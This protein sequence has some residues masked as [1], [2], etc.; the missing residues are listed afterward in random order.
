MHRKRY[1]Q[2]YNWRIIDY[3]L[4][5]IKKGE[6]HQPFIFNMTPAREKLQHPLCENKAIRWTSPPQD[7]KSTR[8][9]C[10]CCSRWKPKFRRASSL[11]SPNW[12]MPPRRPPASPDAAKRR[13]KARIAGAEEEGRPAEQLRRGAWRL[14]VEWPA[15]CR[16]GGRRW[17]WREGDWEGG[18]PR[19]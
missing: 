8:T 16:L 12:A 4:Y 7:Q 1:I 18:P 5:I 2:L 6:K 14:R 9:R 3:H 13:R 11:H 19:V 15:E 10:W 17:R